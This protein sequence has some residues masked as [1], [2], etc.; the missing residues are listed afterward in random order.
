VN[1]VLFVEPA[2][3]EV[4]AEVAYYLELRQGLEPDFLKLLRMP[5]LVPS[6]THW[7]AQQHKIEHDGCFSGIF[8]SHWSIARTNMESQSMHW[9]I[10]HA[11]QVIGEAAQM[12]A[13]IK[14]QK[15]GAVT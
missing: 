11:D 13:N 1:R 10:M 7:Q 3:L 12:T 6:H 14:I 9:L 8:L 2:R 5:Q 4:L 15:T